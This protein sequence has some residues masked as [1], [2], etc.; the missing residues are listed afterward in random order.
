MLSRNISEKIEELT[1]DV[2]AATI[3]SVQD[4]LKANINA[5]NSASKKIADYEKKVIKAMKDRLELFERQKEKLFTFDDVHAF[6]FWAGCVGNV[7]TLL[8][9][10]YFLFFKA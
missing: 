3:K 7:C 10:I 5:L 1:S 4:E 9:L 2:K 6:L 8:L